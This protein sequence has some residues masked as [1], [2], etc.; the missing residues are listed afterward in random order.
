MLPDSTTPLLQGE[1]LSTATVGYSTTDSSSYHD[2]NVPTGTQSNA[3]GNE[4]DHSG[5]AAHKDEP[6]ILGGLQLGL[7]TLGLSL[8]TFVVALDNTIIATAIPRITSAFNSLD[9]VGWYG[10]TYL[11]TVTAL[12]PSFGRIYIFF[13]VKHVYLFGV[14]VFEVGSI[15][16]AAAN[17][18]KMFII[19]R[20]VAGVGEAALYSGSMTIISIE[21][22]LNRRPIYLSLISS[23]YAICSIIGPVIGGLLTDR[24]SWRWCFWIN[25][26]IGAVA[27]ATVVA[28]FKPPRRTEDVLTTKQKILEV[29][30]LGTLLLSSSI[31]C[32]LVSLQWWGTTYSLDHPKVWGCLLAFCILFALFVAQQFRRDERAVIP[33]RILGQ[34]TVFWSCLY[35][36]FLSMGAY[37]H[38]YYLPFYFQ[39]AKGTTA[40]G[41]GIRTIPYLASNIVAC[42]IIG[43]GTTLVGVFKPFMLAGAAIFTIG[44]ALI[45][46]LKIDSPA[47]K[48]VSY[49]ILAGLGAE[50]GL[51][52]PFLAVQAVL[53]QHDIPTGLAV[54][55]CFNSL[56]GAI[57]ISFAQNLFYYGL[58]TNLPKYAP[59]VPVEV[60]LS[61]G[62][63]RLQDLVSPKSLPSVRRAYMEALRSSFVLAIIVGGIGIVCSCFV[64]WKSIKEE[65]PAPD[66]E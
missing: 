27:F 61:T 17:S 48:W 41:S 26:P 49:E 39:A 29:D 45:A 35:S 7:L 2:S 62:P 65:K 33:P 14:V 51:Q 24:A 40:E 37:T 1:R 15:L 28:F 30:V 32:L 5:E 12:Q 38:I 4:R 25:L 23:V 10:S 53:S 42:I 16:C 36:F 21:V 34:K 3:F 31:V 9:D 44:S 54:A 47:G 22:P 11:L 8:A 43:A 59:E 64:E 66:E 19:G 60:V 13:N 52:L 50:A 46:T 58:R 57:A 63:S 20:A 6:V 56:G 18:S 55:T